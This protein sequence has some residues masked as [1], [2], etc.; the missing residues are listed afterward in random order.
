MKIGFLVPITP[1]QII[2][3]ESFHPGF[4]TK[5]LAYDTLGKE[6]DVVMFT[7]KAVQ[8]TSRVLVFNISKIFDGV[9]FNITFINKKT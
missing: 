3:S 7:P 8:A 5:V 9:W 4:V 1:K 6:Y 2:I